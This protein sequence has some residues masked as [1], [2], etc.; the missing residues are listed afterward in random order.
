MSTE[1]V[2]QG[3]NRG[4]PR[5]GDQATHSIGSNF[6][7]GPITANKD[8]L[9]NGRAGQSDRRVAIQHENPGLLLG[10]QRPDR[11]SGKTD[12]LHNKMLTRDEKCSVVRKASWTGLGLRRPRIGSGDGGVFVQLALPPVVKHAE[13]RIAVLLYLRKHDPA[14]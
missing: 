6:D 14:P 10:K 5:I 2:Q 1:I 12:P 7:A 11:V 9:T 4:W 8:H 13:G 3:I